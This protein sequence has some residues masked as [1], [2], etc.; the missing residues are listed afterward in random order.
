MTSI[1]MHYALP[2]A[3]GKT[4]HFNYCALVDGDVRREAAH[5]DPFYSPHMWAES[6][7]LSVL[8]PFHESGSVRS[9][10]TILRTTFTRRHSA[11]R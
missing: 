9:S 7:K 10:V 1:V 8:L 11:G 6:E 2:A 5:T 4:R 3:R